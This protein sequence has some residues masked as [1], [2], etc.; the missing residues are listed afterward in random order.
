MS[1]YEIIV[2][3]FIQQSEEICCIAEIPITEDR[4]KRYFGWLLYAGH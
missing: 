1:D 3:V 4:D 2:P